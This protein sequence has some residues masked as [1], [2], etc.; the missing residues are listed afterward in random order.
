MRLAFA[1]LIS[2]GLVILLA[3]AMP[4]L[5]PLSAALIAL[6][7]A[8]LSSTVGL[9]AGRRLTVRIG[10]LRRCRRARAG[11][12]KPTG[13][14]AGAR[15]LQ[16]RRRSA[17]TAVMAR[18]R[19]QLNCMP[20]GCRWQ[21]HWRVASARF[22][23]TDRPAP[24]HAATVVARWIECRHSADGGDQT[25]VFVRRSLAWAV[26]LKPEG[27]RLLARGGDMLRALR[28]ARSRFGYREPLAKVIAVPPR[29]VGTASV[30]RLVAGPDPAAGD[31]ARGAHRQT[32]RS[33]VRIVTLRPQR[34][35]AA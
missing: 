31:R 25:T 24:V 9:G 3:L 22:G 12:A 32:A 15:S 20:E 27:V 7:L 18:L 23:K 28:L 2:A 33:S 1:L 17:A 26:R 5:E 34:R 14:P 16:V 10:R 8:A 30:P 35:S 13:K 4:R 6:L 29:R 11:T 21:L 19:G